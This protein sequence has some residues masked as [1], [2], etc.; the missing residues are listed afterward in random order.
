MSHLFDTYARLPLNAVSGSGAWLTDDEG[1]RYLDAVSGLGVCALGHAHPE[2]AAALSDQ[3]GKLL[4][5]ANIVGLPLQE[6]LGKT[7]AE[8]SGL[9][10]A[11]ISNSGAEANECAFKLA[12]LHGHDRGIERP[13]VLV[14]DRSF[15]GRTLAGLSASGNPAIQTG[16]SPLIQGFVHVPFGDAQ[17]AADALAAHPEIVAILLEPIQG[18]GGVQVPPDDYLPRLRELADQHQA[19]LIFDEI[20]TGMNRT[21]RWFA[22]Q[23]YEGLKPDVMT[24]AKALGNGMP[25]AACLAR[26]E[27]AA[28]MTPGSHGT[29]FGGNPLACR[30]ALTVIDIMRRENIGQQ[31]AA[32]GEY[33]IN[34]LR[35][36]LKGV[37]AVVSI[38]GRGMM[39]GVELD[40]DCTE[41]RDDALAQG[42]II[43]V[44]RKRIVRLLPPLILSEEEADR[45]ASVVAGSI[46]AR[47]GT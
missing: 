35:E 44:T 38:R 13:A 19:L 34:A 5:T 3:A 41:L 37:E 32:R 40:R 15:H 31:A 8:I 21:G 27:V 7:L 25:I 1:K 16:Y 24:V 46:R 42:V 2:V 12:R 47:Y 11:F 18:E 30:T 33:L 10:R 23:H 4:H 36:R 6:A 14:T 28:L 9:D 29:T 20:Q 17:A 43:N 39:I 26:E 22:H 45:V